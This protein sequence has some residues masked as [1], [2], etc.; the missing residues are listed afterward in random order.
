MAN[1]PFTP[2]SHTQ[3]TSDQDLGDLLPITEDPT[4]RVD[5]HSQ[6]YSSGDLDERYYTP[7]QIVPRRKS[8]A[9]SLSHEVSECES[10]GHFP[11]LQHQVSQPTTSTDTGTPRSTAHPP[12]T[13]FNKHN[14]IDTC[15]TTPGVQRQSTFGSKNSE[16]FEQTKSWDH[17]AILSLGINLHQQAT[18]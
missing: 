15:P 17:K 1:P 7:E 9:Q 16:S 18:P 4:S 5:A 8:T 10:G 14:V 6:R 11:G 3:L 13:I 2:D 12:R